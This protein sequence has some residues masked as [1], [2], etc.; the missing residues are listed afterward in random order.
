MENGKLF[1]YGFNEEVLRA[2]KEFNS[3]LFEKMLKTNSEIKEKLNLCN[4][5]LYEHKKDD[6]KPFPLY[7]NSLIESGYLKKQ[8][9]VNINFFYRNILIN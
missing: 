6:W 2:E 5:W 3:F 1:I 8:P 4:T 9:I 7:I